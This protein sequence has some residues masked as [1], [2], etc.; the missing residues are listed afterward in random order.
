MRDLAGR[1]GRAHNRGKH[2]DVKV[3]LKVLELLSSRLCHD[4]ISPIGAVS[5]GLE[6]LEDED[7]GM[8]EDALELSIK[9]ARRASNSNSPGRAAP[10]RLT[11]NSCG[12]CSSG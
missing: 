7:S 6:L 11:T 3:D 5:N 9:S 2:M 10:C 4:L 8:A 1:S 12:R